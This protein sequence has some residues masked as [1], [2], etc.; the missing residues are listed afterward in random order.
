MRGG[1]EDYFGELEGEKLGIAIIDH[2]GNPRHPTYWHSRSYGL[3]ACNIFGL[4]DFE[5]DP[6]KDGSLTVRPGQPLRFRYRVIVH[7]GN[8][9]TADIAEQFRKFAAQK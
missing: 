9:M 7:P 4:H 1:P 3:F 5:N 6:N 8:Q 2:P